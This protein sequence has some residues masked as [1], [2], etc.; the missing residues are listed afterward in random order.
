MSCPCRR[1]KVI[2]RCSVCKSKIKF[3]YKKGKALTKALT[4]SDLTCKCGNKTFDA[5]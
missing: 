4:N 2:L 1:N 3:V 5:V